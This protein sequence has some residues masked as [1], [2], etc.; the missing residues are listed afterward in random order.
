MKEIVKYHNDFNKIQIPNLKELEQNLLMLILVEIKNTKAGDIKR[1]SVETL[2]KAFANDFKNNVEIGQYLISLRNSF[3]KADFERIVRDKDNLINVEIV[4]LFNKFAFV[5]DEPKDKPKRE[6]TNFVALRLSVNPEFEYIVNQLTANFTA[7]ELAEFIALSGKYTK[8][9][10]RLL[11]QY[12]NTGYAR[13]E[14]SEFARVMDIPKDLAMCDIDKRILKPAIKE[15]TAERNLFDMARIPFAKLSYTKIKGK[16]RG[17]GG[18]VIG[19]EFSFT[20][21]KERIQTPP[22]SKSKISKSSNQLF[23]KLFSK[24]EFEKENADIL[25]FNEK[26]FAD[27]GVS[28]IISIKLENNI[29]VISMFQEMNAN[30][31]IYKSYTFETKSQAI[32]FI[33]SLEYLSYID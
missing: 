13:F 15:L 32:D 6:W 17:R 9:L 25:Q 21:E 22:S 7:F 19:I 33:N 4:N 12:K 10:Y 27:F 18:N 24:S 2:Q 31:D 16:G 14:W 30:K 3:F 28:K 26:M 23:N 8:T 11:K 5:F 20:P 1:L 29:W